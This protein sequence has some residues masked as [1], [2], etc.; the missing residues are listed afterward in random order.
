MKCI[1]YAFLVFGTIFAASSNG[2]VTYYV[3]TYKSPNSTCPGQP[4]KSLLYY[5]DNAE[6]FF[7][8]EEKITMKFSEG[9]HSA[10]CFESD[11]IEIPTPHFAM[12]GEGL[13]ATRVYCMDVHFNNTRKLSISQL[14]IS[15]W[16][17][18]VTPASLK[19]QAVEFRQLGT[20]LWILSVKMGRGTSGITV[21][22]LTHVHIHNTTGVQHALTVR[23]PSTKTVKLSSCTFRDGIRTTFASM[24]EANVTV[25]DCMFINSPVFVYDTGIILTG[26]SMFT[27]SQKSP[28]LLLISGTVVLSGSVCF[29]D[30]SAFRGAAMALYSSLIVISPG[31]DVVFANNSVYGEGGAIY[32]DLGM[33]KNVL[34][35]KASIETVCFYQLSNCHE[36]SSYSF[37]FANNSAER[38]GNDMYGASL[39]SGCE[40]SGNKNCHLHVTSLQR[41]PSVSSDPTRV[42]VCDDNDQP[43]CT[44]ESYI[45]LSRQVHPGE[46]FTLPVVVVGGDLGPTVGVVHSSFK[47]A[48][49]SISLTTPSQYSQLLTTN[50]HCTQ[51]N[52]SAYDKSS[53][54]KQTLNSEGDMHLT[55]HTSRNIED[56]VLD[57]SIED[58]HTIRT[59][60]VKIHISLSPCPQGFTLLGEPPICDCYPE[61][62]TNG[63]GC[64]IINGRETF[65]WQGSLWIAVEREGVVY[66]RECPSNYCKIDRK[67]INIRSESDTQCAF[68]R[69]GRLCGGCKVGYSLAIGSSHC[70]PC[71]NNHHMG[72]LV[73]FAAAG[74]LLV[75]FINTLNL[76][77]TQGMVNGI[78]FYAN[79]VWRYQAI[80]FAKNDAENAII[81]FFK[82]FVAWVN[83][84]FGIE[85]CFANGLTAFWKAWLEFVFPFYIWAIIGLI[86][87]GT[88][89]SS[90]LTRIFGSR[91]VSILSTLIL[92]S[93]MK[94]LSTA[95]SALEF[96]FLTYSE[97]PIHSSKSVVWSVDAN[98]AYLGIPHVFL[99]LAAIATLLFLWLPYTLLLLLAQW[100]RK[101]PKSRFAEWITQLHPVYDAYLAPLK[102]THQYWFG[103]LLLVRGV[104]SVTF[105]STLGI[106]A[107]INL[108]ILLMLSIILL[109]YI[110]VVKPY[111]SAVVTFLQMS[112]IANLTALSGFFFFSY[113]QPN[114]A[115]LRVIGVGLSTGAV[116]LK[117]CGIVLHAVM[118][119]YHASK[120]SCS[121]KRKLVEEEGG[122]GYVGISNSQL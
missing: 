95:V 102:H 99:F 112:S 117:F 111:N 32:I 37:H 60:P 11:T 90:R 93:Y 25:R 36:N 20:A 121:C 82:A 18:T 107:P 64:K 97:Y 71:S 4:C 61:L 53:S 2:E 72:L 57:H 10:Y 41:V 80:F 94:L 8:R 16:N 1:C 75:C 22:D 35:Q 63:V 122:V 83:L 7:N 109:L 21:R 69:A 17:L 120:C 73:F 15:A 62:S 45:S 91:A 12:I 48:T 5:I 9:V 30:N 33:T 105:A 52:Y 31:A 104:L 47:V 55:T 70:V 74:F 106:S 40:S 98:L 23:G 89:H 39:Q 3:K 24:T 38:G 96:S 79:I 65:S 86:I 88:R 50:K 87:V 27:G 110:A 51:L 26:I 78:I 116:F 100:L 81:V 19:Q 54:H 115:D 59:I 113:T 76:T 29:T 92:L 58:D 13:H 46:V 28:A 108:F 49:S 103:V 14:E 68:N 85:T 42:C 114:G 56:D 84:D 43:Q 101:L 67:E 6:A 118:V 66:G 77:V 44:N 34:L 119:K